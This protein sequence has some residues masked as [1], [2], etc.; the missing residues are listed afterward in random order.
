MKNL[1]D[2]DKNAFLYP[3]SNYYG[4]FSPE[5]LAFNANLQELAHKVSFISSL[6]T[7]GKLSTDQACQQLNNLWAEFNSS[8][9]TLKIS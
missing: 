8:K 4:K 6:H 2:L 9:E 7:G 5:V 1:D 3:K